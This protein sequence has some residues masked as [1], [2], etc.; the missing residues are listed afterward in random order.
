MLDAELGE[1]GGCAHGELMVVVVG[2]IEDIK[3][4][5]I[6]GGGVKAWCSTWDVGGLVFSA[7]LRHGLGVNCGS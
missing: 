1:L 2:T 5:A 6:E 4:S 3:G 7:K